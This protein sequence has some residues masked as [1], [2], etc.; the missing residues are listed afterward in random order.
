[1]RTSVRS[2]GSKSLISRVYVSNNR[3]VIALIKFHD[4]LPLAYGSIFAVSALLPAEALPLRF[5]GDTAKCFLPSLFY[6]AQGSVH[7]VL[8]SQ[9]SKRTWQIMI[10]ARS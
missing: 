9:C 10:F 1:M 7:S 8:R 2:R 6:Q 5:S 4:G 3:S